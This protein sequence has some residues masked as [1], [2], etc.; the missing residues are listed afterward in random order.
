MCLNSAHSSSKL[1]GKV[2][3]D[4]LYQ[5]STT[6]SA[7]VVNYATSSNTPEGEKELGQHSY[8][9]EWVS[10]FFDFAKEGVCGETIPQCF[11][12]SL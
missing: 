11:S 2:F 12:R 4:E 10:N 5:Y 8:P 3:D 9:L 7:P 6:A 1:A